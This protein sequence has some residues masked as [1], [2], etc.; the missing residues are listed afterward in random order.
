MKAMFYS[1][2]SGVSAHSAG[3]LPPRGDGER[4]WEGARI[5]DQRRVRNHSVPP[6]KNISPQKCAPAEDTF[7]TSI[8]AEVSAGFRS[9]LIRIDPHIA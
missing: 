9:H 2:R 7:L 6:K 4:G 3:A 5:K 8:L 1:P